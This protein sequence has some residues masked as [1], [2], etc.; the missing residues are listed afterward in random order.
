MNRYQWVTLTL[1]LGVAACF[2]GVGVAIGERSPLGVIGGIL[3]A[4]ALMG[5]G[6]S[7]KRKHLR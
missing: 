2:I 7:Y 6:F 4:C 1:A 5:Y 3:G